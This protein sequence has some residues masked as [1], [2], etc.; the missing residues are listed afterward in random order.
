[1]IEFFGDRVKISVEVFWFLFYVRFF[2][3]VCFM[4]LVILREILEKYFVELYNV[5]LFKWKKDIELWYEF[6]IFIYLVVVD[7]LLIMYKVLFLL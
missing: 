7:W 3:L 6:S 4:L 2:G 1:M 5:I